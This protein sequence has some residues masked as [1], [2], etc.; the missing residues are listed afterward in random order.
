MP[1]ILVNYKYNKKNDTYSLL[2][3]NVVYAD[4]PIAVM[5]LGVEYNDILIVPINKKATVVEKEEYLSKNEKFLLIANEDGS[6]E[7]HEEG[8]A[9]WLPKDTDISKLRIIN[10]QIVLI[11][12][13]ENK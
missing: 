1:Q 12:M 7:E 2:N 6:V 9:I 10:G 13:E 4:M 5:E 8:T 11:E 3:N